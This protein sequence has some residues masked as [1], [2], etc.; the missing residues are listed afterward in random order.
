MN[1]G[2]YVLLGSLVAVY[3]LRTKQ[4]FTY[5]ARHRLVI[6]ALFYLI[7]SPVIIRGVAIGHD[8]YATLFLGGG[9][10]W[11]GV[12]IATGAAERDANGRLTK[13]FRSEASNGNRKE[14]N[15]E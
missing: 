8:Q 15:H 5:K 9:A 12:N 2:I 1:W 7:V 10:L 6:C 14:G 3:W 13:E 11:L 4:P